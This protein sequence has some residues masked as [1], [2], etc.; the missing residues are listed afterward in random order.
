[1]WRPGEEVS[2]L[3]YHAPHEFPETRPLAKLR[4]RLAANKP[5]CQPLPHKAGVT[6]MCAVTLSFFFLCGLWDSNS[7]PCAY[8]YAFTLWAGTLAHLKILISWYHLED[9]FNIYFSPVYYVVKRS[10][11]LLI[12][13]YFLTVESSFYILIK[14]TLN[15]IFFCETFL[16]VTWH[17]L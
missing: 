9:L 4:D 11:L 16:P 7:G 1:M 2:A 15:R 10:D 14:C 6:G 3:L 5:Q 12:L 17:C 8:M 13:N